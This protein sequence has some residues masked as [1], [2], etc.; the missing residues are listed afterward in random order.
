MIDVHAHTTLQAEMGCAGH[1]GPEIGADETGRPWFRV[2]DYVLDGVRYEGSP[3]TDAGVRIALND[4]LG[5]DLQV[6]S[7]NPLTYFHHVEADVAAGFCRQHNDELATVVDRYPGRLAGFAQLPMQ[8]VD[9]SV[10]ELRRAV[11]RHGMLGAY[12]GTDFGID[13]DDERLDAFWSTAVEL[14]VPVFLHPAPAGID[15]PLRDPR[16]RKYDLDLSLSSSQ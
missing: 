9:A 1:Y 15:G 13:L 2:G 16:I 6:L 11:E 4:H 8:S 14:D 3:L 12:V 7:P 5:I 10:A